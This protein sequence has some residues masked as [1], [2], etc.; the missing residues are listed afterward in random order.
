MRRVAH[1][2][3]SEPDRLFP[4][5]CRRLRL[6]NVPLAPH[7]AGILPARAPRPACRLIAGILRCRGFYS[8]MIVS[9]EGALGR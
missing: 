3:G 7:E 2:S 1:G 5:S 8:H 9:L 4:N 6:A